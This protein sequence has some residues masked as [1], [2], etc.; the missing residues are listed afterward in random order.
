MSS[1]GAVPTTCGEC[2]GDLVEPSSAPVAEPERERVETPT[3][4][5]PPMRDVAPGDPVESRVRRIAPLVWVDEQGRRFTSLGAALAAQ[6]RT[7]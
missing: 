4:A 7:R 1:R 6:D 5:A 3:S 2:G